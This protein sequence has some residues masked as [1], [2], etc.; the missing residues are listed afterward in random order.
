M[1]PVNLQIERC[2]CFLIFTTQAKRRGLIRG[3]GRLRRRMPFASSGRPTHR[4]S[5]HSWRHNLR[6]TYPHVPT[7]ATVE[8]VRFNIKTLSNWPIELF[9]IREKKRRGATLRGMRLPLGDQAVVCDVFLCFR[10]SEFMKFSILCPVTSVFIWWAEKHT[11]PSNGI[12]DPQI[13]IV[14]IF[15]ILWFLINTISPFTRKSKKSPSKMEIMT[16]FVL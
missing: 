3:L 13:W 8:I 12:S 6:H 15:I 9:L 14:G 11:Q 1:L 2:Q 7:K 5:W 10:S 16:L 4:H